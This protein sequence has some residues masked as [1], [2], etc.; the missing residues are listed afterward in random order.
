MAPGLPFPLAVAVAALVSVAVTLA[1]TRVLVPLLSARGWVV[2]DAHKANRQLVPRPGGPAIIAGIVAGE[3]VVYA[4]TG[5]PGVIALLLTTILGG[6]IGL[7]D[8]MLVFRGLAK[9]LLAVVAAAPLLLIPGAYDFHLALPL[10]G[11]VRLPLIYPVLVLLAIPITAN[12]FNS[13]DVLNGA[14][15]GFTAIATTGL[16][17]ALAWGSDLVGV[18]SALPVAATAAAF[19]YFHR[20]PSRIFPGDSGTLAFGAAYGAL[21]ITS[22]VEIV[23][24]VAILPA[25]LNSF[26]FLSSVRRVVEHREV[27]VRPVM[28]LP[29]GQLAAN[30]NP[31]APITLVRLILAEGPLAEREVVR[32]IF[33]LTAISGA[34][35]VVTAILP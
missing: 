13:I 23:A 11:P 8:D 10:Y 16:L 21:A 33:W 31:N 6:L 2:E 20:H 27:K 25:V 4:L 24:V 12:T 28:L 22:H 5:S 29:A 17:V 34:M 15:S 9:P 3:G 1:A 19:Y 35:A 30:P 14:L 18:L 26:F 32:A 7:L